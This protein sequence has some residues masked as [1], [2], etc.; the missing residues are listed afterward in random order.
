MRLLCAFVALSFAALA[1]Q[2]PV[3]LVDGY[4]LLCDANA[5]DSTSYFNQLQP[6]L[7]AQSIRVYFFT[8]CSLPGK[9]PIETIAAALGQMI[10]GIDAPQVDLVSHSMGGLV[11]RSYLAGKQPQP[12]TFAPPLDPK[13]RKW[14]S[15]ATP[16]FGAIL[17][18]LP[19]EFAPDDQVREMF[20][21]SQFIFDLATWNQNRDN[22][23]NVDALGVVGN[24]GVGGR[25]DSVVTVTS[26]SLDFAE[27]D[28]RTRIIPD[29]HSG[30]PLMVLLG[31]PCNGPNIAGI[32]STSDLSYQ[33]I[34]SFLTGTDTWKTIGHSPSQDPVL[35]MYGG[36]E[37]E[38]RDAM[39]KPTGSPM[40]QDFVT[41]VPPGGYTTRISKPGPQI[42]LAAPAAGVPNTLSLAPRELVSIYGS[43]LT[44]ATVSLNGQTLQ[45]LYS[46]ANQINVLFPNADPGLMTLTVMSAS[47][48]SS[49][50]VLIEPAVPAVFV[51]NGSTAAIR[52]GNYESIYLTGLGLNQA[53]PTVTIDGLGARVTY[54]GPAPGFSG[55]DQI[56]VQIPAGA[57]TGTPVP[58]VVQVGPNSSNP[59]TLTL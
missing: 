2:P 30:D 13:V 26:A 31:G 14:I 39:D 44:G 46:G 6:L 38:M 8:N 12:S 41:T 33:I 40:N 5:S 58:V 59:T 24:G 35:S 19:P 55:L 52:T 45:V 22:L 20:P 27:P 51:V 50:N 29:C 7:E 56:N 16:N 37:S 18:L 9:P 54:A 11:V 15:L 42:A 1:Q 23:H 53:A 36:L 17:T 25:S 21:N 48:Q 32:S 4:H 47:G 49:E 34:Q 10:A 57:R 28:E 3:V 43:N